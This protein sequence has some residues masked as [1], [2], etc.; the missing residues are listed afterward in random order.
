MTK[1][2][3]FFDNPPSLLE[4]IEYFFKLSKMLDNKNSPEDLE[5]SNFLLYS[6]YTLVELHF[7]LITSEYNCTH[8]QFCNSIENGA[9]KYIPNWTEELIELTDGRK[10][11]DLSDTEVEGYPVDDLDLNKPNPAYVYKCGWVIEIRS[12]SGYYLQVERNEYNSTD[13]NELELALC[14]WLYKENIVN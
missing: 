9:T 7:G 5:Q 13:I 2:R 14:K 4:K 6:A 3:N 11:I 1:L 8:L 12:G 10:E